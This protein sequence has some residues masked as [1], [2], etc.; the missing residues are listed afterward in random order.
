[1]ISQLLQPP[2]HVLIRLVLGDVVDEQRTDG[3]AVVGGGDG[4]VALLARRVPD[5]GFDGLIVDLD[6][7]GRELYADGG[8][9]VEVEL[10]ARESREQVRLADAAVSY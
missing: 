4:A 1:M 9:A 2:R 7:A 3:A 5:L 6:A 8:L 10:I